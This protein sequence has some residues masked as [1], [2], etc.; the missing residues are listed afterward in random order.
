MVSEVS[1]AS[2]MWAGLC[3]CLSLLSFSNINC[4]PD[5][6]ALYYWLIKHFIAFDRGCFRAAAACF[7]LSS[8]LFLSSCWFGSFAYFDICACWQ[9]CG[10]FGLKLR[11]QSAD[12]RVLSYLTPEASHPVQ[13]RPHL[14]P[15]VWFVYRSALTSQQTVNVISAASCLYPAGD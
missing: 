3:C 9:F 15:A 14:P 2:C 13:N 11:F 1:W 10:W 4:I 5:I 6:F 7:L 12:S 8:S